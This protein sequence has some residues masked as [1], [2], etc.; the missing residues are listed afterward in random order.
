MYNMH[1]LPTRAITARIWLDDPKFW[2]GIDIS[3]FSLKM[4]EISSSMGDNLLNKEN[5]GVEE[6]SPVAH[7]TGIKDI[8]DPWHLTL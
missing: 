6:S 1:I 2:A 3:S 8:L 7:K 5:F 4:A